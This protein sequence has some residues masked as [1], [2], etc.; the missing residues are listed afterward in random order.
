MRRT[1]VVQGVLCASLPTFVRMAV[2]LPVVFSLSCSLVL[3]IDDVYR[4]FGEASEAAQL[5]ET[6]LGTEQ[7]FLRGVHEGL[8]T[9]TLEVDGKGAAKLLEKINRQTLGQHIKE[10]KQHTDA[11]DKLEP[12]LTAALKERNRL[13]HHF[14]REHNIRKNTDAGR[15]VMVADLESIHSTL[16]EAYKAMMLLSGIDLDALAE[17]F[18]QMPDNG[19]TAVVDDKAIYHLPL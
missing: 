1:P 5:L 19:E 3:T 12:L 2:P 16:L 10:T 14:Y 15:A 17:R 11:L 18:A 7:L 8:I 6:E 13:L 9:S 4:K